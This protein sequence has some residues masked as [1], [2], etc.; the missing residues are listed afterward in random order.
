MSAPSYGGVSLDDF[1][2]V[3]A[4]LDVQKRTGFG[5]GGSGALDRLNGPNLVVHEH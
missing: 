5:A 2:V 1:L 4:A 3:Q